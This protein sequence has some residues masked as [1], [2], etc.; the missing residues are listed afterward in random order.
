MP[1]LGSLDAPGELSENAAY[2][3]D[4]NLL[5]LLEIGLEA[6]IREMKNPAASQETPPLNFLASW[7]MRNNPKHSEQ[8]KA[9][10]EVWQA[11][12]GTRQPLSDLTGLEEKQQQEA[13]IKMQAAK[14]G[15]SARML[16]GQQ[17]KE[18]KSAT[19]MA[20]AARGRVA[21]K[22]R[23]QMEASATKVQASI[24]GRNDRIRIEAERK[25]EQEAQYAAATRLQTR[26]RGR[27]VRSAPP[28]T[29][30]REPFAGEDH[31]AALEADAATAEEPAAE[32][33]E[34]EADPDDALAQAAAAT[35]M[36]AIQRGKNA[37]KK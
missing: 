13:A 19:K 33:P 10:I 26:V 17:K 35:K 3:S 18:S 1:I 15:H 14:R 29:S 8:G 32:E 36:Q 2:L 24:R 23:Q 4:T 28:L 30:P 16:A 9:L 20:A 31:L 34:P 6:T 25:A 7:L 5:A 12:L 22:E 11:E 37:R 27:N 21:R